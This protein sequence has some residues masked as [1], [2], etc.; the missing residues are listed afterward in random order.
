MPRVGW[1]AAFLFVVCGALRLA[2]FNVQQH[3]ERRPLL[4]RPAHPG[5]GGDGRR[6]GQLPP[7][8]ASTTA[9]L[10]IACVALL[11]VL[12]FLMVS[13]F[14]YWSFK[15]VDL[16]SRRSYVTIVGIAVSLILVALH[17]EWVLLAPRHRV[18]A[19][20]PAGLPGGRRPPPAAPT[21]PAVGAERV[22]L[23]DPGP[24][25]RPAGSTGP[26]VGVGAVVIHEGRVLLIRRGKEPLRGRW[27][28][29][30][31]TVELGETLEAALVRE[32]QEE[33]G[34]V[35]GARA[36]WSPCSTASS[37]TATASATTT[38]SSTTSATTSSGTPRAASDAEDVALV[39]RED[40]PRYDLPAKALEVVLDGFRRRA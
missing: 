28:V 27:V 10:A 38:S 31:G 2:R 29:P 36:R 3:V 24:R 11:V 37:A 14:R 16:K 25:S 22:A 26:C 35:G 4:R 5:R 33:T 39:A 20:R 32:V 7:R 34:L 30:G 40:L 1:L 19:V 13:T 17:T 15:N 12:S 18:L 8:A 21:A 9:S 23:N 6:A